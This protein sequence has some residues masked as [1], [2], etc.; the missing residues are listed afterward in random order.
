MRSFSPEFSHSLEFALPL[1]SRDPVPPYTVSVP[2]V[3][4]LA[5]SSAVVEVWHKVPRTDSRPAPVTGAVF[6]RRLAPAF[7]DV[8]LGQA[9]VPLIELLERHKGA[10]MYVGCIS[11]FTLYVQVHARNVCVILV[12]MTLV[13]AGLQECLDGSHYTHQLNPPIESQMEDSLPIPVA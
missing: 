10:Y 1:A 4:R 9:V 7:R 5:E 6:G 3:Q 8:C 2:L 13:C 11:A 12:G